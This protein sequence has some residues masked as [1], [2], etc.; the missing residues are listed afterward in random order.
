MQ[1]SK[2]QKLIMALV[3]GVLVAGFSLAARTGVPILPVFLHY[4]AQD[5]FEWQ[6]PYTLP[7]KIREDYL[8][9][10]D[11]DRYVESMRYVRRYPDELPELTRATRDQHRAIPING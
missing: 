7:D 10:Y 5:D 9:S 6:D 4:E 11:G 8:D 1:K 3:A 2:Q